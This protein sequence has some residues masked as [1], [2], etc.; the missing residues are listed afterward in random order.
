[1]SNILLWVQITVSVLLIAVILLQ[2]KGVGLGAAF[3]GTGQ[4]YRSK[5]GLEKILFWAT[6]FLAT[7]FVLSALANL[8]F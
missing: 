5:R 4:V 8:I 2:Q 6:I 1:M 3:G 7:A